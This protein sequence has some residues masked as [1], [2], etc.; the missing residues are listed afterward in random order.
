[1]LKAI[2]F[3]LGDTLFDSKPM[4]SRA[5]FEE[6]GRQAYS[7]L[8]TRGHALPEFKT[9]F[10]AHYSAVRLAY[11]W[12]MIRGR[13]FNCFHVLRKMCRKLKLDLD[14]QSLRDL[15]WQWYAPL[16]EQSTVADDVI[17]TLAWLR[18]RGIKLGLVSNTFVP[19]FVL[20][21]HL[22]MHALLE[23]LPVRIYSSEIG[24][25]KPHPYIFQTALRA[26]HV[27][28]ADA[29]FVGDVVRN[30]VVGARRVGM[31]TVLRQP[32]ATSRTHRVADFVVRRISEIQQILPALDI[33]CLSEELP[34]VALAAGTE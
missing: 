4:K 17:P 33:T 24:Y 29:V 9:Y 10:Q 6:A 25:R 2:L 19:G 1:M 13:E 28:A 15:G 31:R 32:A 11:V 23:Y 20:D 34:L 30:D 3:D 26:L 8:R 21:R 5:V 14:E 12:S 7:Y 27:S 22:A 16:T 18:D